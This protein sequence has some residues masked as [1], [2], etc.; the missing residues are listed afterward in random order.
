MDLEKP[1]FRFKAKADRRKK[2]DEPLPVE[3]EAV[4]DLHV[5]VPS[6]Q[7][8]ELDQLYLDILQFAPVPGRRLAYRSETFTLH[9]DL[10]RD[11]ARNDYRFIHV[12][13]PSLATVEHQFIDLELVFTRQKSI[14]PG[15]EA[16]VLQD[17]DGNWLEIRQHREIG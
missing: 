11:C 6:A 15:H 4:A 13:V 2:L 12:I 1:K 17:P 14:L 9:F 10:A 8:K 7:R 16:L 5:N 3:L